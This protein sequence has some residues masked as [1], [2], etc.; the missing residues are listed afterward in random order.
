MNPEQSTATTFAAIMAERTDLSAFT[1]RGLTLPL[2]ARG[3]TVGQTH[4]AKRL[5]YF[6]ARTDARDINDPVRRKRND[7]RYNAEAKA[8][9][10]P[11]LA[12][13][14]RERLRNGGGTA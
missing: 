12:E 9:G 7:R 4:D 1:N 2:A 13:Q 8:E 6:E 11:T 14:Y 3:V 5:A 10:M